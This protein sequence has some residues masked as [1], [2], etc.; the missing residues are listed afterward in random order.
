MLNDMHPGNSVCGHYPC[1]LIFTGHKGAL[2]CVPH[3]P[4]R[5]GGV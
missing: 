4:G 3:I 2:C 1:L 5:A